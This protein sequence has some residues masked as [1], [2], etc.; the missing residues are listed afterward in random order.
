MG[1]GLQT[2]RRD[3]EREFDLLAEDL[4]RG[5]ALGYID[6][7]S[8]SDA[9][10]GVRRRVL[11]DSDLLGGT[12]VVEFWTGLVLREMDSPLRSVV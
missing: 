9:V 10:L 5:I 6:K 1:H 12:G 7:H 11:I 3:A 8:R 2:S 4:C